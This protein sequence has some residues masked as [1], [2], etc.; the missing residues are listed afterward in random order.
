MVDTPDKREEILSRIADVLSPIGVPVERNRQLE[1]PEE[2]LPRIVL[3][4]GGEEIAPPGNTPQGRMF[5][6][7][8]MEPEIVYY[9]NPSDGVSVNKAYQS[10][11]DVIRADAIL[12]GMLAR[13][14]GVSS[15]RFETYYA[16]GRT[17]LAG[18]RLTLTLIYD[19]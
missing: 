3:N 7:W 11:L 4:D 10:V 2:D 12:M 9:L 15:V 13:D 1:I 16:T 14:E 5:M 18:F 17:T 6:R 8:R 19:K